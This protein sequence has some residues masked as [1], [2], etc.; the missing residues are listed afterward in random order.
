[1]LQINSPIVWIKTA[2]KVL[3]KQFVGFDA[4]SVDIPFGYYIVH[5]S[6]QSWC[7]LTSAQCVQRAVQSPGTKVLVSA[8]NSLQNFQK[9]R[10]PGLIPDWLHQR[11]GL[12]IGVFFQSSL[13]YYNMQ[14]GLRTTG[15]ETINCLIIWVLWF[16]QTGWL[17]SP[18]SKRL[19]LIPYTANLSTYANH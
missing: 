5:A 1:M 6:F 10:F 3:L 8:L 11:R 7:T 9:S 18:E 12:G 19:I 2:G 16:I 14:P 4:N 13:S 15:Q 17:S